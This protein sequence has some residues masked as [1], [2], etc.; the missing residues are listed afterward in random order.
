MLEG[1]TA[2]ALVLSDWIGEPQKLSDLRGRVVVV[3]YWAT[4]CPPCRAAIPKNIALMDAYREQGLMII[5]VHDGKKGWDSMGA[6]ARAQGINYPLA[7]DRT[8]ASQKA[9]RVS[10]WP[11]YAVIDAK[12][13]VRAIGL[14]PERVED[15]VKK[16]L[17]ESARPGKAANPAASMPPVPERWLEGSPASRQRLAR[18]VGQPMEPPPIRSE[19][20]LNSP[21]LSLDAL[22]GKVVLLD[23]WATWCGPCR[24]AVPGMNEMQSRYGSAGL[25]IIGV[26]ESKGSENME[27]LVQSQSIAYPVCAD[28]GGAMFED[29]QIDGRPDYYLIDRAGRL[30]V[31]DCRNEMLEEAVKTLLDEAP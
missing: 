22:Q 29:Y 4:W 17:E 19:R 23:F 2:P 24:A 3:D 27:A 26:C 28:T 25:V 1:R 16:L 30:R 18:L 12:G 13:T 7:V 9:W 11:T 5:G 20:W 15:V 21:P 10:F 14:L 31:A 6:F 8:G